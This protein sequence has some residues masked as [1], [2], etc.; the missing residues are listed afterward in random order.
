MPR[1]VTEEIDQGLSIITLNRP[2]RRNAI[3]LELADDLLQVVRRG[4]NDAAVRAVLLRGAGGT[5]SVGGDVKQMASGD[6]GAGG[7]GE[8]TIDQH[9][10][11]LRRVMEVSRVL[12]DMHKPVVCALDGAVAGGALSIALACDVRLAARSTKVTTAFAKVALSGDFGG[13]WLMTRLIGSARAKELFLTCPLL[14]ADEAKGY[15]LVAKVVDDE[16]LQKEAHALAL[17]LAKGPS[18]V[19]GYMKQNLNL[20]ETAS[21]EAALDMEA[22]HQ[23]RS[24]L[25]DDHLEAANAFV[26]KRAPDFKGR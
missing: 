7:A 13:I 15:G 25:L 8:L 5:F 6:M 19:L 12:H 18:V 21:F 2:E 4:A 3:S 16:A 17:S 20:A 23:R 11:E 1:F 26:Q 10:T 9:V 22:L 24:M 14:T